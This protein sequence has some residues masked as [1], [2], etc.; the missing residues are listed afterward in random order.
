MFSIALQNRS[1]NKIS[2]TRMHDFL[3]KN[4]YQLIYEPIDQ[5][6]EWV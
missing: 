4:N 5:A 6:F 2:H 1:V 3:K